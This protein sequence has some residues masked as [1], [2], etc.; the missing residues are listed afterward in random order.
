[1]HLR[2]VEEM[3]WEVLDATD[4]R[5]IVYSSFRKLAYFHDP[6]SRSLMRRPDPSRRPETPLTSQFSGPLGNAVVLGGLSF[7]RQQAAV[8]AQPAAPEPEVFDV[9]RA[10]APRASDARR[11]AMFD[12]L[13]R[14][15]VRTALVVP[16]AETMLENLQSASRAPLAETF[17]RWMR[18]ECTPGNTCVLLFAHAELSDV[19]EFVEGLHYLPQLAAYLQRTA[20]RR[21]APAA[22][23]MGHADAGELG[24]L[25]QVVRL[26][27]RLEVVDWTELDQMARVMAAQELHVR[28]WKAELEHF[29]GAGTP[30]SITTLTEHELATVPVQDPR[31]I[32]ER[33][34]AMVGLGT[35]KEF[36]QRRRHSL[37][38]DRELRAQGRGTGDERAS[39]HLVFTGNPGTGKTVVARLVGELYRDLGLL[40]SGHLVEADP[41]DLISSNV[42]GTAENT[43]AVIRRALDGVLFIDEAYRLSEQRGGFGAESIDLL[44]SEM[45]NHRD[46]LVVI[47]AGYPGRMTEFMKS[48][49]GL[50]SRFPDRNRIEFPN[51]LPDEL[52]TILLRMLENDFGLTCSDDLRAALTTITDALHRTADETFGN[53]R[54]MREL[55]ADIKDQWAGRTRPSRGSTLAPATAEDVPPAYR[56]Y[57]DRNTPLAE[58]LAELDEMVGLGSV[59]TAIRRMAAVLDL[60]RRQ[61]SR[62]SRAVAPHMLFVG[63]PGTGKTTVAGLIGRVFRSLG[64]LTNGHV[65]TATRADL[66]AGY[67]G[68]TA[69]KTRAK[70][71]EALDGVLLID[72][73]Y[74]LVGNAF[75]NDF[76]REAITELNVLMETWRGRLVVIAA[77]YPEP[78]ARFLAE[79][80]GL[81]SRFTDRIEFPDYDVPEL[82]Q[83]FENLAAAEG[84]RLAAGVPAKA[85]RWLRRRQESQG[86]RFGNARA[87]R[88]L[89]GRCEQNLAIRLSLLTEEP[90]EAVFVEITAADVPEPDGQA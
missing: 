69:P 26:R 73:A 2:T 47:V 30:L 33:L 72:E 38:A 28:H 85:L 3:L 36:I 78:M 48:N 16:A 43:A 66:V 62:R 51:Y 46:R 84:Y 54:T 49:P 20:G 17:G 37:E 4:Y 1:M 52:L 60:R 35:V 86:P 6:R 65:V 14:S 18:G 74:D 27:R 82:R 83:I 50:P 70:V 67:I 45:E 21:A 64:L 11:V 68:Q 77:G 80:E 89:F 5:R 12:D 90:D 8:P 61:P 56:T 58:V 32:W 41:N 63:A 29:A 71:M 22:A 15:P 39:P 23:R 75:G 19:A 24:R 13:M 55:A 59:K 57:L 81:A 10:Q 40:R 7:G 42:G 76:G 44:L 87:V 31:G 79:N 9:T 53:A 88:E 25:V 34:D